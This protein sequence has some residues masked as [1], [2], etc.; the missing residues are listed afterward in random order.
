MEAIMA[1]EN[2]KQNKRSRKYWIIPI[3]VLC[4]FMM[5]T[6]SIYAVIVGF[7]LNLVGSTIYSLLSVGDTTFTAFMVGGYS[8][9]E[10]SNSLARIILPILAVIAVL[11]YALKGVAQEQGFGGF[12]KVAM[13]LVI[14]S[15][16][17]GAIVSILQAL[18]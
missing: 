15:I 18:T 11:L 7:N 1:L 2:P 14:G 17:L 5:T 16:F 12:I 13:V 10:T 9:N 6:V 8:T 3:I 4:L